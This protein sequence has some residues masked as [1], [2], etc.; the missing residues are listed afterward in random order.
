MRSE[1]SHQ[2]AETVVVGL[3]W[4]GDNVLALPTYRALAHRFRNDGGIAVAA[5]GKV[6]SLLASTGIFREVIAWT[7]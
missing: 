2:E 7:S 5:P 4:V 6:A 3:N 1:L